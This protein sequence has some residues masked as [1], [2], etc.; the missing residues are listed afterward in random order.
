MNVFFWKYRT[1][2]MR[3]HANQWDFSIKI[4]ANNFHRLLDNF[5]LFRFSVNN[6]EDNTLAVRIYV[7]LYDFY[8]YRLNHGQQLP[9]FFVS[10]SA[11]YF[12]CLSKP[13]EICGFQKFTRKKK[14]SQPLNWKTDRYF[15]I[16]NM[17]WCNFIF[18]RFIER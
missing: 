12:N 7:R 1:E 14:N 16:S 2:S 13:I 6:K 3:Q 4:Y 11:F 18:D 17:L 5:D 15:H 8:K 10:I 9:V